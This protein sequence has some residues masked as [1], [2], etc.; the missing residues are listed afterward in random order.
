MKGRQPMSSRERHDPSK[1]PA[2]AG[3]PVP[4][5]PW[6]PGVLRRAAAV[7]GLVACITLPAAAQVTPFVDEASFRS[8]VSGS[9]S[10]V[11]I[12][13][14]GE[15]PGRVIASGDV[16][17]GVTFTHAIAGGTIDLAVGSGLPTT[18]GAN[19]LGLDQPELQD[20]QIQHGDELDLAFPPSTA[21]GL[22][23]V[24]GDPLVADDVLLVTGQGT[25]GN[26]P[27]PAGTTSDGGLVY[28]VGLV[29]ERPFETAS[30]RYG[31]PD[32]AVAFLYTADDLL[33][34]QADVTEIPTL[35]TWGLAALGAALAL[36][37]LVAV[38]L[39][40]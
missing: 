13:F 11:P 23:I 21:L 14:E 20:R 9:S 17:D 38:R 25:A 16:V 30:I 26:A 6:W 19:F 12:D 35:G 3:A 27:M 29:A 1:V 8:A 40:G 34:A 33:L 18:S 2:S 22:T 7:V 5:R 32:E 24:S 10:L 39:Q 31:P 36:L 28:F 15:A 37:G 4:P